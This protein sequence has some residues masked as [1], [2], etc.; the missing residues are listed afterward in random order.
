MCLKVIGLARKK[1]ASSIILNYQ[2][3]IAPYEG[4]RGG[5]AVTASRGHAG[6]AQGPVRG[7]GRE[8]LLP[9]QAGRCGAGSPKPIPPTPPDRGA[10]ALPR[11]PRHFHPLWH[12]VRWGD[13]ESAIIWAAS[14]GA[15]APCAGVANDDG[16]LQRRSL[17]KPR[18]RSHSLA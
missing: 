9:T 8:E 12:F 7:A 3:T 18:W 2:M 4:D 11:P 14:S 1:N 13:L 16:F 17:P 10:N 6:A 5:S 15:A